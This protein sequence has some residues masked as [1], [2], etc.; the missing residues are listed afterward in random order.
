[1]D[2]VPNSL[3]VRSLG[4]AVCLVKLHA[5]AVFSHRRYYAWTKSSQQGS[6]DIDLVHERAEL[7]KR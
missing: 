1:V 4:V 7:E 5:D 3:D 6:D 2:Y